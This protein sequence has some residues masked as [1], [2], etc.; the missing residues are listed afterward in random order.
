MQNFM[1]YDFNIT[2]IRLAIYVQPGSGKKVHKNRASDGLAINMSKETNGIHEYA[3]AT[4]KSIKVKPGEIIYLPK[5]SDYVLPSSMPG[6]CYAINFDISDNVSFEPFSFKPK[7]QSGFIDKFKLS[8]ELW[9]GKK[10]AFNMQ[11]KALLYEI[12]SLMQKEHSLRYIS[13]KTSALIAPAIEYI[14]SN[15]T[16]GNIAVSD[17]SDMCGISE[18]Y[19]RRIFNNVYGIS[20]IKYINNLKINYAKDLIAS[21]AYSVTEVCEM[22]GYADISYFSRLFKKKFAIPPTEYNMT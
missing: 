2:N 7:N 20:P 5:H 12:I 13:K 22:S 1:S 8:A 14:H 17:L 18:N 3:F 15:Y 9:T 10:T 4:G 19:L 16:N 6:D 11:C 21:G